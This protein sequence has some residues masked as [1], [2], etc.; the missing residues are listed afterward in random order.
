MGPTDKHF[1]LVMGPLLTLGVQLETVSDGTTIL[2]TRRH[3]WERVGLIS[4][5]R[6]GALLTVATLQLLIQSV[7]N[8]FAT[9]SAE[10]IAP[11]DLVALITIYS[12]PA[13]TAWPAVPR[14]GTGREKY[15]FAFVLLLFYYHRHIITGPPTHSVGEP[16]Q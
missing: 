13:F 2:R 5:D 9:R 11:L 7:I 10:Q 6:H 16:D 15:R 12:R 14:T 3:T 8:R 1:S 4:A